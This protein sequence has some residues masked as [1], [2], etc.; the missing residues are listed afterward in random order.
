MPHSSP[1]LKKRCVRQ[2]NS[3][4]PIA[5][6]PRAAPPSAARPEQPESRSRA[7][8]TLPAGRLFV[9]S[10]L[11]L[12]E[13]RL[14]VNTVPD[15][16]RLREADYGLV[17]TETGPVPGARLPYPRREVDGARGRLFR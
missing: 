12:V 4:L 17:G 14:E 10:A 11:P 1:S 2:N 8:Q 13:G 9:G 5:A 3:A 15:A 7:L 16:R 6:A